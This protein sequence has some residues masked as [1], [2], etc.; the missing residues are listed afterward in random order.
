MQKIIINKGEHSCE[1]CGR[2]D[3]PIIGID[4][5][6]VGK[7]KGETQGQVLICLHC[8]NDH[9]ERTLH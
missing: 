3:L 5:K 1:Y 7:E 9:D 6:L 4:F 2:N 8:A